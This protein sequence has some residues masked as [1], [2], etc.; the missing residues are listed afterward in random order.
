[1]TASPFSEWVISQHEILSWECRA[2]GV[3]PSA[4]A[5][6]LGFPAWKLE[7]FSFLIET[8][9]H[10][11]ALAGLELREPSVCLSADIK[12]VPM[13][14]SEGFLKCQGSFNRHKRQPAMEG[15]L[16]LIPVTVHCMVSLYLLA[17]PWAWTIS[18]GLN[19]HSDPY[20]V[21][22]LHQPSQH[23]MYLPLD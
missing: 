8:G 13:P 17:F 7:G 9:S 23:S 16:T 10:C 19:S 15:Q 22:S 11:I 2:Q 1:M 4:A 5:P 20:S 18:L 3:C 12:G 6:H 14:G 21:L